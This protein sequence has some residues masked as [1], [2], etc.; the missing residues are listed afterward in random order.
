M[1]LITRE[2]PGTPLPKEAE[3]MGEVGT[4]IGFCLLLL[5]ELYVLLYGRP[6]Y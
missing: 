3:T 4:F 5:F 6:K 2:G 1:F